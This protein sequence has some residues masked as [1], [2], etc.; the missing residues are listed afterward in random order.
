MWVV[1]LIDPD[2][3]NIFFESPTDV[4]EETMYADW[5]KT[6]TAKGK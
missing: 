3:Y 4:P 1:R 5:L 6:S 2:G